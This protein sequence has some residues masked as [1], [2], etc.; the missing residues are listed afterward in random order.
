MLR[1][2]SLPLALASALLSL[3]YSPPVRACSVCGCDPAAGTLGLDRPSHGALRLALDTRYLVKEAGADAAL[4]RETQLRTS[5]RVQWAPLQSL[6]VGLEVPVFLFLETARGAAGTT[7]LR[8]GALR[9]P[10]SSLLT[11]DGAGPARGLGDL[12]VSARWD[13][14][15]SGVDA[16][17]V[18]AATG[19][20]KLPTGQSDRAAPGELPDDHGQLGSGS[21]DGLLGLSYLFG[22]QPWTWYASLT[23]RFNGVNARGYRAGHVLSSAVGVRRSFL[24]RTL[25]VSLDAQAR[26][27]RRD[28]RS[29]GGLDDDSGGFLGY[30]VPALSWSPTDDLLLRAIVQLPVAAALNG[31]Q[32]E[33]PV[34][35][36]TLSYD[37]AL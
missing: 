14:L 20:L 2:A 34:A 24:A 5:A 4:E 6:S 8:R 27:S 17:H 19:T 26:V 36:A 13:F 9:G 28:A 35:Y 33:K 25:A 21:W 15:R 31:V 12:A 16:R 23:G 22:P 10:R 1:A 7:A 11:G 32:R 29:E 30:A 18:L 3:S 37:F